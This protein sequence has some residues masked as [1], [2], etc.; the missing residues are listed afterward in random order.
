MSKSLGGGDRKKKRNEEY[1]GQ[2]Q[3]DQS[4]LR[5]LFPTKNDR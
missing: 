2:K 5:L 3:H 4:K 1:S